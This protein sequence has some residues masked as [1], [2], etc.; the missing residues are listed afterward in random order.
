MPIKLIFP[1]LSNRPRSDLLSRMK[2]CLIMLLL[3]GTPAMSQ[4]DPNASEDGAEYDIHELYDCASYYSVINY[5]YSRGEEGTSKKLSTT[6]FGNRDKI[7]HLIYAT[8][9]RSG[10]LPETSQGEMLSSFVNMM[11]SIHHRCDDAASLS[12]RFGSTCD[13]LI[14]NVRRPPYDKGQKSGALDGLATTSIG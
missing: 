4:T 10:I 11:T 2:P 5:C 6:A 7:I 1:H 13:R 12:S 3:G 9:K 14:E 8:G